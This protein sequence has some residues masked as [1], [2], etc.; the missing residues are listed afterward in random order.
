M[1]EKDLKVVKPRR[2]VY[3]LPNLFT[4]AALFCGFYAIIAA[5]KGFFDHAAL[6]IY[7]AMLLDGLDGRVARMTHTQSEFGAQLDS[8]SDMICFGLAPALVLYSWVLEQLGKPG[9]L[10]AFI[11]TTCTALRLARF[12]SQ[13]END[14][15][16]Y[17]RGITTTAAAG[18]MASL[19]WVGNVY[20]FTGKPMMIAV[21]AL[22]VLVALLKVSTLPYRS[23]KDIDLRG[24]VPF[25]MIIILMLVFVI[26]FYDTPDVLFVIFT[27]YLFSGPVTWLKKTIWRQK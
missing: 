13:S 25:L 23:F 27:L 21:A 5:M 17:C 3:L 9:W 10:I 11:Y 6:S 24:K 26:I 1:A 12:N 14:D 4:I 15:K 8:M 18:F 2:G 16:R 19:V 7:I 22:T 20:N